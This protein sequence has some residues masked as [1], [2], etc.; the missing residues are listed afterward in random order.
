M[1]VEKMN[2]FNFKF[3][4]FSKVFYLSKH[5]IK[6]QNYYQVSPALYQKMYKALYTNSVPAVHTYLKSM[7]KDGRWWDSHFLILAYF[8]LL[9]VVC[10]QHPLSYLLT[11]CRKYKRISAFYF[12]QRN[13]IFFLVYINHTSQDLQNHGMIHFNHIHFFLK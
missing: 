4:L 10:F 6:N 2:T 8:C 5:L 11:S 13:T 9:L 3:F 1:K 7:L 12:F